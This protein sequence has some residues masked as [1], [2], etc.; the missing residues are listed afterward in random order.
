MSDD[1]R[2]IPGQTYAMGSDSHYPEEAPAHRVT[3]DG[4]WMESHQVTNAQFAEFV[5][6]TGYLT[7]AERTARSGD[8][9]AGR[10]SDPR[11]PP[12]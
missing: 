3:V 1:L 12:T 10:P 5:D 8:E 7:V 9:P 4:F 2:W 11:R 6:T